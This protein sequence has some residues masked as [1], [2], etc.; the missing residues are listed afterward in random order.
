M[1][2]LIRMLDANLNR[3]AEGLRVL[4]DVARFFF[5]SEELM[6]DFKT[7][8]HQV[9]KCSCFEINILLKNRDSQTDIGPKVSVGLNVEGKSNINDLV[10]ANFKRVQE[11][12]RSLEE[13]MRIMGRD[14][15]SRIF[16]NIRYTLYSIE[17][18]FF[19]LLDES[20]PKAEKIKGLYCITDEEHSKGRKNIEVVK[21]MLE[22]GARI[23]QYREKFK[24]SLE[25][26]RECIKL[27]D[28]TAKYNAIFIVNDHLE[29]ARS[30]GA[31]GIHF[32]QDDLPIEAARQITG[33]DL[34]IGMSTH[35]PEQACDA[36]KRGADYIGVGPIFKT[37]TKKDVCDPVGFT[38]LEYAVENVNIPFV[39]IGGI[40]LHNFDEI[41]G[42][43]AKCISLVTEITGAEDISRCVKGLV[44]RFNE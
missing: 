20:N 2:G 27:R 21:A 22:G 40:K 14:D 42:R 5:N 16:E 18:K 6:E 30:I 11:A 34:I 26:Y 39:A 19:Q 7:L 9:R 12:V 3:A 8:R 35:S 25:K 43:G 13:S 29:I 4:E 31:D 32:G 38:Y 36:I 28:L 23:V 41:I 24:S 1:D 15:D 17:K 10:L 33:K 44:N 37:F